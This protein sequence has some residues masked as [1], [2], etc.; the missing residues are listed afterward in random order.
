MFF[1]HRELRV[2]H[3]DGEALLVAVRGRVDDGHAADAQDAVEPVLAA[4]HAA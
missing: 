3:L 2:E 1:A 4:Q